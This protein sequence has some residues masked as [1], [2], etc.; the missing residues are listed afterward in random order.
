M[1]G[2][3]LE[4][5]VAAMLGEGVPPSVVARVFDLDHELVKRAQSEV[6]VKRYTAPTT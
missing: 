3:E 2:E 4:T 1:T 5:I 6:R